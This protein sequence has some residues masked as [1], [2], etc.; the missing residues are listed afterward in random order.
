LI[1]KKRQAVHNFETVSSQIFLK[2]LNKR[3]PIFM[4]DE[5]LG[6]KSFVFDALIGTIDRHQDNWGNNFSLSK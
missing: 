4:L 5:G 6:Q 2:T 1:G 3:Y